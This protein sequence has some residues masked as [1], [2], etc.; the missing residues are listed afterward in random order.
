MLAFV[1]ALAGILL[2]SGVFAR[3]A[4]WSSFYPLSLALGFAALVGLTDLVTVQVG[5]VSLIEAVGPL[6]S[7]L[8]GL[9]IVERA[10]IGPVILWMM[11]AATRLYSIAKNERLTPPSE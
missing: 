5:L 3:E 7:S 2:L 10:Y 4:R 6:Y 9:G 1:F 8:K 11:L